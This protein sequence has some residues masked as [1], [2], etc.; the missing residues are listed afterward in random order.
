MPSCEICG[1]EEPN[2]AELRHHIDA[3]HVEGNGVACP[4]CDLAGITHAEMAAHIASAHPE[5]EG[6]QARARIM[7]CPM[8]PY[9]DSDADK[10]Q[11][12]VNQQHLNKEQ[13]PLS[14]C[15]ICQEE[16]SDSNTLQEHV[17][18]AHTDFLD[19]S[20]PSTSNSESCPVCS[21]CFR[22]HE[23]LSRHVETHFES[24]DSQDAVLARELEMEERRLAGER[25]HKRLR[26]EYGM[27]GV[28]SYEGQADS[29][30]DRAYA[31][32]HISTVE[33]HERR[34]SAMISLGSF[35]G[36]T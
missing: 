34:V 32:G 9:E 24:I 18:S 4:L 11:E 7:L 20:K 29:N 33:Y 28:G 17:N 30:L 8:C 14:S 26:A 10:L 27:D 16:F 13:V 1:H 21:E 35:L 31:R 3:V 23:S 15:P 5:T 6:A 25:E 36:T 19:E 12:H 2:L 22:D